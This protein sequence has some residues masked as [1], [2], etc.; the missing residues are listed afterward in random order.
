MNKNKKPTSIDIVLT[1]IASFTVLLQEHQLL[2]TIVKV[3]EVLKV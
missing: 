1:L 2:E 3:L